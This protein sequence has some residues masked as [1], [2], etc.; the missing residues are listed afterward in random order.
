M[1]SPVLTKQVLASEANIHFSLPSG[2]L[3]STYFSSLHPG[4]D[5]AT[6]LGTKI[7]PIASGIVEDVLY[8]RT[9]YGTHVIISH[10]NGVRSLYAHM[11]DVFVKKGQ[12]VDVLSDLGT[13]GLTGHTSG[14]HTHLEI[15]DNNVYLDP[16]IVIPEI[17]DL[18]PLITI[19]KPSKQEKLSKNLKPDF[20]GI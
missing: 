11:G 7:H 12:A 19:P 8:T 5:I 10:G 18:Q 4:V 17:K 13:V 6:D 20:S 16:A 2:G 14:P 15:M 3:I 9:D 1:F